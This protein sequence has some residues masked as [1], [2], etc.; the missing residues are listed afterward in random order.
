[1]IG[2]MGMGMVMVGTIESGKGS[3]YLC[4]YVCSSK[5]NMD[6]LVYV[7]V[8]FRLCLLHL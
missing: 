2:M 7:S 5:S 3:N 6:F 8:I 1:M 4:G